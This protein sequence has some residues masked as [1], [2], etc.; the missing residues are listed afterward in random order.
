[1]PGANG[2]GTFAFQNLDFEA[3]NVSGYF[4]SPNSI[5]YVPVTSALP[6]WSA[7]IDG[8]QVQQVW[9]DGLSAGSP[10]VAVIDSRLAQ[11]GYNVHPFQGNYSVILTGGT[12]VGGPATI[13]QTGLIPVG[14]KS[15]VAEMAWFGLQ[16][17]PVVAVNGQ[18]ITMFPE[19]TFPQYTV[20]AGNIAAFA[21]QT[22]TITFTAPGLVNGDEL[23]LDNIIFSKTAVPE[24]STLALVGLAAGLV[25]PRF[26][27]VLKKR[28]RFPPRR[29]AIPSV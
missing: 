15:L 18:T 10:A 29:A 7:Y 1:M 12:L 4:P 8:T 14:T 21:G 22:A 16:A 5:V 2:Q 17:G 20:Y 3:A 9:Y 11:F 6:G 19:L 23:E 27:Q 26:L 13:S 24:P 25:L 28:R